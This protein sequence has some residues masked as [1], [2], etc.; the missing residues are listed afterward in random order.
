MK[1]LFKNCLSV[2]ECD[3]WLTPTRFTDGMEKNYA[4]SEPRSV[5]CGCPASVCLA[6]HTKATKLS[7]EYRIGGK[8]RQWAVVD[9]TCD[10]VLY[11]SVSLLG[12]T[13]RV[14]L[15]LPGDERVEVRVYLPQLVCIDLRNISAN[16]PLVPTEK[17]EKLWLALGDSI[18]QGMVAKHPSLTYPTLLS[19]HLD[20]DLINYGV[21]GIRFEEET[22]DY[23][24]V[25]PDM[26]TVALGCNDFG[27]LDTDT[28]KA[29]MRAYL[30]KLTKLY[31]CENV[32][33]I[34]PIWRCDDA[35]R[36]GDFDAHREA[37]REIYSEYSHIKLI[38]GYCLV[39]KLEEFYGDPEGNIH[40]NDTGFLLY[41]LKLAK[42]LKI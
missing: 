9:V 42:L 38:D 4:K 17:R 41:A 34:L 40:P 7:F 29:N 28:V 25:E 31:T 30:N 16:A 35:T 1:N 13:G 8:A 39:P 15:D 37:I 11:G 18:T 33:A 20:C 14:E 23:I 21:G 12:T 10:G 27:T 24:G 26:I 19:E 2:K 3:G 36:M 32:Y 5:R 6:F 22:L